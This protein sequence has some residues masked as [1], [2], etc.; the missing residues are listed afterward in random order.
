MRSI[1]STPSARGLLPTA[2]CRNQKR[3]NPVRHRFFMRGWWWFDVKVWLMLIL[4]G[5]LLL[6]LFKY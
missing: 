1:A 3:K 6:T 2:E 4:L 5:A